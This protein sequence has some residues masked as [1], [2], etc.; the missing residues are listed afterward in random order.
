MRPEALAR[1]PFGPSPVAQGLWHWAHWFGLGVQQTGWP[2]QARALARAAGR[3]QKYTRALAALH[4]WYMGLGGWGDGGEGMVVVG[5]DVQH[6]I[7]HGETTPQTCP[8][9]G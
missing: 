1:A 8:Y 5:I 9:L 3:S 6:A 2:K 4:V 7:I